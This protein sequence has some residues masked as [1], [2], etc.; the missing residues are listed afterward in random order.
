MRNKN[1]EIAEQN[2]ISKGLKLARRNKLNPNE[3]QNCG[4]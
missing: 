4:I 1:I 3:E 2:M